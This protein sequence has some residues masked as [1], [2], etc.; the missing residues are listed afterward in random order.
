[1]ARLAG[2]YLR[3]L[4]ERLRSGRALADEGL[5]ALVGWVASAPSESL[6]P[7]DALAHLVAGPSGHEWL[8][9]LARFLVLRS[10]RCRRFGPL[11]LERARGVLQGLRETAPDEPRWA[12]WLGLWSMVRGHYST[13]RRELAWA[14]RKSLSGYRVASEA[15]A[16]AQLLTGH[17]F[18]QASRGDPVQDALIDALARS[19]GLAQDMP[20][21]RLGWELVAATGDLEAG[22]SARPDLIVRAVAGS[23]VTVSGTGGPQVLSPIEGELLV[24]LLSLSAQVDATD[25][26]AW[27]DRDALAS[28]VW[29]VAT[30]SVGRLDALFSTAMRLLRRKVETAAR[31]PLLERGLRGLRIAS[32]RVRL[33]MDVPSLAAG[34]LLARSPAKPRG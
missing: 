33:E 16:L 2:P 24:A 5:A 28:A 19:R 9:A 1:M 15:L 30:R 32:G 12:L 7:P 14:E 27:I 11:Y 29:P 20:G 21:L 22:Q 3:R 18:A 31:R 25:G 23:P 17:R 26:D 6:V 8:P 13:A 10:V 34:W 4:Q